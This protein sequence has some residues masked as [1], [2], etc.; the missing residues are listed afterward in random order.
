MDTVTP[1]LQNGPSIISKQSLPTSQ[2]TKKNRPSFGES[3]EAPMVPR[4]HAAAPRRQ[5]VE[6]LCP[7]AVSSAAEQGEQKE[8]RALV[9]ST[10]IRGGRNE[11]ALT[12]NVATKKESLILSVK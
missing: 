11:H 7:L 5:I 9:S 8:G 6:V 4:W 2:K 3:S 12:E 1:T 10:P